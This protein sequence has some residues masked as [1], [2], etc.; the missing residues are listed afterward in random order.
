VFIPSEAAHGLKNDG[1]VVLRY[2]S[3][4]APS[5]GRREL[6]QSWPLGS[7][8]EEEGR[9]SDAGHSRQ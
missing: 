4:A 3:A 1:Q 7:E 8:A 2:F 6:E 9:R 5:F